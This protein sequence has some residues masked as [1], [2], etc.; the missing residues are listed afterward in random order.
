M[1]DNAQTFAP[2]DDGS[3]SLTFADGK[4][5]KAVKESDLLA[6]K[7]GA[8]KKE[9]ELLGQI[10]EANRKADETHQDLLKETTAREQFETKAQEGDTLKTKVSELETNLSAAGESRKQLEEQLLG[11]TRTHLTTF[12][13]AGE[14]SVKDKDQVQ[15]NNMV[16]TLKALGKKAP[17]NYDGGGG[18]GGTP[19]TPTTKLEE[20]KGEIALART[21]QK[22]SP[23]DTDFK[24]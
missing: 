14:D 4:I 13:Q 21:L 17:A 18:G 8:E 19:P 12:Y 10:A 16:E 23:G 24:Q 1:G 22:Q 20:C 15:L 7:G 11:M 6:V 9:G 2:N 5:V 3:F